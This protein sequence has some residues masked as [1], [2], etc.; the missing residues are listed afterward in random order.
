[1]VVVELALVLPVLMVLLLGMFSG[2]TAW[3]QNLSMGHGAR[4]A[5]RHAATL[6][7]PSAPTAATVD[8]WLDE[9]AD[10]AVASSAGE[11]AAGAGRT[12][13][14]AYVHP[15]G[16]APLTT[17]SRTLSP[18]GARSSA[19]GPCVEDDQDPGVRRV[20]VVVARDAVLDTGLYRYPLQLR[21]HAVFAYEAHVGL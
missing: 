7:L 5:A 16:I 21:Q 14:V 18:T 8:A 9:V 2:A 15:A 12:V 6:P 17:R 3:N 1:V 4:V 20:Q 13:C 10:L 11:M 19:A